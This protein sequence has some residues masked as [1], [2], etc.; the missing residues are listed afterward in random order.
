MEAVVNALHHT[1]IDIAGDSCVGCDAGQDEE[2]G[3]GGEDGGVGLPQAVLHP[4]LPLQRHVVR[5][6][7]TGV[8]GLPRH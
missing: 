3:G 4:P 2:E 8:F 7:V 1:C 6:H 5:V